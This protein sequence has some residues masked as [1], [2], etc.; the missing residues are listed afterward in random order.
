MPTLIERFESALHENAPDFGTQLDG[1]TIGRLSRYYELLWKWNPR[2]HLVAPCSP[3]EFATRHVLESLFLLPHL[4]PGSRVIDVGS[5][6]GLP[7]IPCLIAGDGLQATLIE[8][9][10]RKV[11]FL[12]EAVRQISA[13]AT[14]IAQRFEDLPPPAADYVTCRA[15]ERLTQNFPALVRW[16]PPKS[17]LLFFGGNALHQ[18]IESAGMKFSTV[19]IPRSQRRFLFVIDSSV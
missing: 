15:L 8:S 19:K 3:E 9:S 17:S 13:K 7:I 6:G 14:V 4:R 2:L 11:V 1:S 16:S 5:G 18:R 10:Q 12:R